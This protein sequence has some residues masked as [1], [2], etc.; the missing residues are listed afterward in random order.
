MTATNK[1]G[2]YVNDF[3]LPI[4]SLIMSEQNITYNKKATW[5]SP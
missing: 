1:I 2:L 3:L 4:G 5:K